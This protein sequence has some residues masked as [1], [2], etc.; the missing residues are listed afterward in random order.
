[1]PSF[2]VICGLGLP[3]SKI[4]ITPM[5][6][7]SPEKNFEDFFLENTSACVVGPWPWPRIFFVSLALIS[8]L[9]FSTPPLDISVTTGLCLRGVKL[10]EGLQFT[11]FK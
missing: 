11:E 6:W 4:L 5:N 9:G 3:Q 10:P 7:R 8:I 2:H 1:M